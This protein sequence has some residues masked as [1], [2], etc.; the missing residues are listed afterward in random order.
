VDEIDSPCLEAG[1]STLVAS[2]NLIRLCLA[3]GFRADEYLVQGGVDLVAFAFDSIRESLRA[4]KML[5]VP[6]R[7]QTTI[8]CLTTDP[9]TPTQFA[10][11]TV[12]GIYLQFMRAHKSG[13]M[14]SVCMR[15]FS[16]VLER[17]G[18]I[19]K[20]ENLADPELPVAVSTPIVALPGF[21]LKL[22]GE[23]GFLTISCDT[24]VKWIPWGRQS[25]AEILRLAT[26]QGRTRIDV[27][28]SLSQ[29]WIYTIYN[30]KA[31][32]IKKIWFDMTPLS[33][34]FNKQTGEVMTYAEHIEKRYGLSA[35]CLSSPLIEAVPEKRSETCFL[36]PE[37][38]CVLRPS[39]GFVP[40]H[41]VHA[42][43]RTGD[44][45][46]CI[47]S[48]KSEYVVVKTEWLD[49]VDLVPLEA[50]GTILQPHPVLEN[51]KII[52]K[53]P[54]H[55]W[56]L[57]VIGQCDISP[58]VLPGSSPSAILSCGSTQNVG[59]LIRR[60]AAQWEPNLIVVVLKGR[61][62]STYATI[63][64]VSLVECGIPCQVLQA[65]TLL[66][67]SLRPEVENQIKM[68]TCS[69]TT[70]GGQSSIVALDFHRFGDVSIFAIA[71]NAPAR[72]VEVKYVLEQSH[73]PLSEHDMADQYVMLLKK[74]GASLPAE[75]V[76]VLACR[77]GLQD[78][79]GL[80][81][82]IGEIFTRFSLVVAYVNT[83][84][85]MFESNRNVPAGFCVDI[86]NRGF[87]LVP[88]KVEQG[89]ALPVLFVVEK[90]HLGIEVLKNMIWKSYGTDQTRRM[91]ELFRHTLKL[92]ELIGINLRKC[93]GRDLK[94]N[95]E[96]SNGWKKLLESKKCFYL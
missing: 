25:V 83:E 72:G 9:L 31:Y 35:V 93:A 92:S 57:I 6:N 32:K 81:E 70:V 56:V 63:K 64:Y 84:I 23:T 61:S 44:R 67:Q 14:C 91:P 20:Y 27:N 37:Y 8:L 34:F 21:K 62:G 66:R 59:S 90:A 4:H 43:T 29:S 55:K 24:L 82:H 17:R 52:Q 22:T 94:R 78:Q 36:L 71:W 38:C 49:C 1:S 88:H 18:K 40:M 10:L 28:T 80:V 2:T 69:G 11:F 41:V 73:E 39:S 7:D 12:A 53:N 60:A 15:A 26:L 54:T 87:Y 50:G 51:I 16:Q 89:N 47:E 76:I 75:P 58:Y 5:M 65:E 79:K 85:R 45:Q 68:K 19:G 96:K 42:Q 95:L 86:P 77:R 48:I 13:C 33:T 30:G 46:S 3:P 74:H